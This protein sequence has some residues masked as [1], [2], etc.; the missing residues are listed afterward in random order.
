MNHAF[1]I[2]LQKTKLNKDQNT[3]KYQGETVA[4]RMHKQILYE[5]IFRASDFLL[6]FQ[7]MHLKCHI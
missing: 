2:L 3:L 7:F 1:L 4:Y 5:R 6:I